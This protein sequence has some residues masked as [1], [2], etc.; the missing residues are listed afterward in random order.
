MLPTHVQTPWPLTALAI[1]EAAYG[2]DHPDVGRDLNNLA[3]IWRDLGQPE[4]ARPL[5][6]Q[7]LAI[8][9]AA[10]GPDHPTVGAALNNLAFI[11]R[12]L[13]QPERARP[14]AERALA[15]TEAAYGPDH[16]DVATDLSNLATIWRDLG[17]PGGPGRWPNAPWPSTR[18]PT[19]PT[20]RLCVFCG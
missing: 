15:I 3:L 18:P 19:A 13:G 4:R 2:P 11:W 10:Y 5:A 7:A 6:E 20:T 8:T 1:G 16:P 9:E 14:L 12:D 17:Q